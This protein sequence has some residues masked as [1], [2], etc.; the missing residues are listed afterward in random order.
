MATSNTVIVGA[1]IIGLATAYYLS[2]SGI[3]PAKSIHIVDTAEAL[4][5]GCASGMAAGFLAEDCMFF[6][7]LH[8]FT[9]FFTISSGCCVSYF[10]F[11]V[12]HALAF[13]EIFMF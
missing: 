12:Y 13:F 5:E 9:F 4:F 6:F 1:G 7:G 3:T 8:H 10:K 2:E 11:F